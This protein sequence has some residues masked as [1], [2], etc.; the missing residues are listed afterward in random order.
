MPGVA[1]SGRCLTEVTQS[2]T[3]AWFEMASLF[4]M[5]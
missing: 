4:K 1:V 5:A 2:E 3:E